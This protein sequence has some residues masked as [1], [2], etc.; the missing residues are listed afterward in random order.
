MISHP[1]VSWLSSPVRGRAPN[2]DPSLEPTEVLSVNLTGT[3]KLDITTW[4]TPLQIPVGLLHLNA[5][6]KLVYYA[7]PHG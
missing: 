1:H 3:S 6:V 4:S 7:I 2:V 5:E